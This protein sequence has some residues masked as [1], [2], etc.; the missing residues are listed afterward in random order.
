VDIPISIR[1]CKDIANHTKHLV[2]DRPPRPAPQITGK[3]IRMFA[4][5]NRPAE[6]S[7]TFTFPDGSKR[8]AL[9]L[10]REV[11]ADWEQ[12]LKRYGLLV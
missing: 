7:F 5:A 9:Q 8:D 4:G 10:A 2:L 6:A 3:D 11:V 12:L 1:S